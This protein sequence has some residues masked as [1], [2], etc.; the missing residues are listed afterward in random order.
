MDGYNSTL[1]GQQVQERLDLVPAHATAIAALQEA[2]K[3]FVSSEQVQQLITAALAP[4][5]TTDEVREAT[6]AAIASALADYYTKEATNA[7]ILL[8]TNARIEA[9]KAEKERAE[10]AEAK[11]VDIVTGKQLSTEDFTTALKQKLDALPTSSDLSTQISTAITNALKSYYTKM[12][13]DNLLA[14]KQT[15][16]QVSASITEALK[17]YSTTTAMNTAISSA[18]ADYLT[19]TETAAAIKVE[20]DRAK[21]VEGTLQTAIATEE[22]RA[23]AAEK[24]NADAIAALQA[25]VAGIET[26]AEGY[27]RVAGSSSPALSYKSYKYHEQGGFGRESAFSLFYPCLVGTKLTGDDEQVGKVLHVLKK[28]GARTATADDTAFSEGQAIWEDIYGG[29][30]AIDGTE[31]DLMVCNV[32]PYYSIDGRHTIDGTEYDVFLKARTP[33][34]WQG[35]EAQHIDRFGWAPD[36]CVRHQDE[37]GVLRMHSVY[38][39]A[40]NGSYTN[41]VGVT[42]RY[43]AETDPETGAIT[44]TFDPEATM[45]GGAG[46]LHTTDLS[47]PDG[48][49]AAMNHNPDTTATVPFMNQTAEGCNRMQAL[50]LSEGGT[51]DAHNAT[52]MG[53][54]F[55]SNDPATAAADWEQ[56]GS[57]AKNGL[58]VQ[59]KDGQWKYYSLASNVNFLRGLSTGT[60]YAGTLVNSWRNPWHIMEAYRAVCHAI[61]NDVH[62]LEW[63]TFEGC[64]YK[65]RSVEGFS[66][67]AQGEATCVVWK[68]I[69]TQAGSAA[70]DPTDRT[71]SIAGNRVEMLASTALLHG[72]TTQ[73]SPSWWTSGLI[74]LEDEQQNYEAYIEREQAAL[75]KSVSGDFAPDAL[76][77]FTHQYQHIGSFTIGGGYARNYQNGALMMPDTN[78]NK[79]GAGLHTYVGKYNW[80]TGGAAPAGKR[81]VRGFRRGGYAG[82]AYLSPLS[83][84]ANHSPSFAY[85]SIGFGTCV[86]LTETEA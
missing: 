55:S 21:G 23:K 62:E 11:K 20:T 26:L 86:R 46:G 49:Q 39:P 80:F 59:D 73:T 18:L 8:E 25:V 24:V 70:V 45:L 16:A 53:S 75:L 28:L 84:Y 77:Q 76:P 29:L 66:G 31:G 14:A 10:A 19:K 2:I 58:R 64:R 15:A 9:V 27:V 82:D 78:A 12:E 32:E 69:A 43:V 67:P 85:S 50:L 51:F 6:T 68:I 41:P 57:G 81:S 42:G 48:E 17:A 79:T 38:N 60:D 37:D 34:T 36:Y 1:T 13:T 74:F 56:S 65:W 83:L 61:R 4:Y 40:W 33:F 44:E 47:L 30:H 35:I 54:G 72:M 22:T 71:T 63:F 5:S 3:A 7:A 52:R